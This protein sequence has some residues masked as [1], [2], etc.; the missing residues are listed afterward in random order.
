MHI[1][2]QDGG[3]RSGSGVGI[4][5]SYNKDEVGQIPT[6]ANPMHS[7]N[8]DPSIGTESYGDFDEED[9]TNSQI[10]TR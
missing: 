2:S 4:G 3:S 9:L 10:K 5:E 8:A 7:T 1:Q 6:Y